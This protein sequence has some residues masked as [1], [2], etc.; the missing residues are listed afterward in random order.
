MLDLW[1][2]RLTVE[3]VGAA[4]ADRFPPHLSPL[5]DEAT[6]VDGG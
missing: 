1:R 3:M 6:S 2:S 4:G 5:P